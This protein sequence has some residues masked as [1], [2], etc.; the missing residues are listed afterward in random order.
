MFKNLSTSTKL[1]VLCGM[2]IIP[3]AATTYSLVAEKRIAIN[4]A[5]KE[6]AGSRYLATVREIYA[7]ILAG[8]AP[9]SELAPLSARSR[10]LLQAL[11]IAE[12]RAAG[13]FQTADFAQHLESTLRQLWLQPIAN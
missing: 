3:I 1:L 13:Q 4:F 10:E 12:A 11:T 7:T 9:D 2:F 8:R 5:R 6:L